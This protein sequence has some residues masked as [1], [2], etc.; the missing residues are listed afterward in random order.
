MHRHSPAPARSAD[1]A[2]TSQPA[3][4]EINAFIAIRDNLLADAE[5]LITRATVDRAGIANNV[6]EKSLSPARSPYQAQS[7]AKLEADDQR[8]RCRTV[9]GR[10]AQLRASFDNL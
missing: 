4:A 8:K 1:R 5:A 3:I 7:L 9:R 2:R 6:L 10:L